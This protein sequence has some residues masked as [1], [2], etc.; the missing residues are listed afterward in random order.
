MK[1]KL[2]VVL[3]ATTMLPMPIMAEEQA[4]QSTDPSV[5]AA[6]D[7]IV[8]TM[9]TAAQRRRRRRR[10][11]RRGGDYKV[12]EVKNGGTLTG[13]VILKGDKPA[14]ETIQI[15]KDHEVCNHRKTNRPR[16]KTDEKNRVAEAILFLAD[17][18]EGKTIPK[19]DTKPV[20]DQKNCTFVPHVQVL[21]EDQPFDIVNSD[22]VAHN[23]KCDQ[24]MLT[25]FNPLQPMQGM[26]S[27]FTIK[28]P[29]LAAITCS[30]HNW[31]KAYAYVLWHPY[32][33]VTGD[34]GSFTITDVP[35][36]EYTL[37][38]WQEHLGESE[39]TVTVE[40]GKTTTINIELEQDN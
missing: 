14:D 12:I 24:N 18:K 13:T 16:I 5:I 17:I 8:I 37:V 15:V 28:R 38:T 22:P 25:L 29:G 21:M 7:H 19:P 32:H 33:A 20:I 36:G 27:E 40:P 3:L 9:N 30:V 39:T 10:P 11:P 2:S 34:D 6:D 26:K 35:P 31:M 1:K 4:S 23:A